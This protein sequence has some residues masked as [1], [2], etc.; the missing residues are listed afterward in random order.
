M[1]RSDHVSLSQSSP[2]SVRRPDA[3]FLRDL[4]TS[5]AIGGG[6]ALVAAVAAVLWANIDLGGY[7][8]LQHLH[9]GPLSLE[10]WAADGG[11][12]LFFFVAGLEL[13]RE[14]V[15]GSLRDPRAAAVPVAA[16]CCGVAV[17]A[18]LFSLLNLGTGNLHGWAIAAPTDI[19]FALA[20]LAILGRRA[21][22]SLRVFLLTLAVV[23]DVIVIAII[24]IA[25]SGSLRI[26]WLAGAVALIAAYGLVLRL[27][28]R[29]VWILVPIA[30]GAWWCTLHSG[31]HAT[32]AG[33][34]LALLTPVSQRLEHALAPWSAG[35]V[36]PV[37]ALTSAGVAVSGGGVFD[38]T[39]FWGVVVGLVV[40]KPLGIA[41]GALISGAITGRPWS[42][43]G[44]G[45]RDLVGVGFMAGI[46]FT[47]ALL[48]SDL[49]YGD[50][51][52]AEGKTAVLMA[53]AVAAV[54]GLLVLGLRRGTKTGTAEPG[55]AAG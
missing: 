41:A 48:V 50:Q 30:L 20:V 27:G 21:P 31:I 52:V 22:S 24:A 3:R 35:L 32:V 16:A 4:L 23:D 33:V 45:L 15:Q 11:L 14:F 43:A 42:A 44:S 36:V 28:Q 47:V 19:A 7:Q 8:H 2:N 18:L 12:T 38:S 26:A 17:P 39:V 54:I 37:F 5:E 9:L 40:G 51:R 29:T 55:D 10:H 1:R 46:G 6:I 34:V 49:A 25:Y 53:S 13:K